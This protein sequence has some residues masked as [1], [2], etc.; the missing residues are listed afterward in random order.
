MLRPGE[1]LSDSLVKEIYVRHNLDM[2][3]GTWAALHGSAS[4][5]GS[6]ILF[7]HIGDGNWKTATLT[8]TLSS[9]PLDLTGC[10][11]GIDFSLVEGADATSYAGISDIWLRLKDVS[12]ATALHRLITGNTS[13]RYPGSYRLDVT[14]TKDYNGAAVT[15]DL[16]K[17][18]E[19]QI[20]MDIPSP[21][22]N[23]PSII[24]SKVFFYNK[25]QERGKVLFG[26]DGGYADQVAA[27][28]YLAGLGFRGTAYVTGSVV[29]SGDGVDRMN[30][31]Q[32]AGV[33]AQGHLVGNYCADLGLWHTLTYQQKVQAINTNATWLR[34]RGYGNG[35]RHVSISGVGYGAGEH[36]LWT[37]DNVVETITGRPPEQGI[38]RTIG[39]Y[40][41]PFGFAG[42]PTV[43]VATAQAVIDACATE[44]SICA[45]I[46]H[47]CSG[48]AGD[49]SFADFCAIA[50]YARAKMNA[51]LVDVVT[52]DELIEYTFV[53]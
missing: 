28:K 20:Q 40:S 3:V 25:P 6:G 47:Q 18:V 11:L 29:N 4:Q 41:Y 14:P 15:I 48:Q 39:Y 38:G 43:A 19:V 33:S 10:I 42:G 1:S 22:T 36:A 8:K 50:D 30:P 27:L 44:Q 35:A 17:I 52:P 5:S 9:T 7:T 32:L 49:I 16:S 46:F 37:T 34:N 13:Y 23:Q 53:F 51:G 31:A 2:S 12:A 24:L 45:F 21:Y 26:F